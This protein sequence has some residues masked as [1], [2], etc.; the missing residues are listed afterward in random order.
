MNYYTSLTPLKD[1]PILLRKAQLIFK[2]GKR[3]RIREGVSQNGQWGDVQP[4]AVLDDETYPMPS[5]IEVEWISI[6]ESKRFCVNAPLDPEHIESLWLQHMVNGL[7]DE[8]PRSIYKYI[9]VGI[10]PC[11]GL[12]VWLHGRK[13]QTLVAWLQANA[14]PMNAEEQSSLLNG[15]PLEKFCDHII[16]E[17]QFP[18]IEP[19]SYENI[20]RQYAYRFVV[21][22]KQWNEER[23]AWV[24]Y[25]PDEPKKPKLAYLEV[26]R[27]DGTYD[28]L[29]DGTLQ[30]FQKTGCPRNIS[31]CWNVGKTEYSAYF[32]LDENK[33]ELAFSKLNMLNLDGQFDVLLQVDPLAEKYMVSIRAQ[34]IICPEV[35]TD[36]EVLAFR[37]RFECFRSKN[38]SQPEGAWQW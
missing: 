6:I 17:M 28:R 29:H 21:E 5:G 27:I 36:I 33:T 7:E 26:H 2:D 12:A 38:Y 1:F 35:L 9:A 31:V 30:E 32:F 24:D 13:K 20:M 25:A 34:D 15:I 19:F 22:L 11:G 16:S 14:N 23:K 3:L 18:R 8:P 10:A 37:N 4:F